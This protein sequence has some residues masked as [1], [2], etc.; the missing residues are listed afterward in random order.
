MSGFMVYDT[1]TTGL[2]KHP[3]APL[4]KQ[5]RIIEFAASMLSI[6]SGK[7]IE[8]IDVLINPDEPVTDEITK[9]TGIAHAD[10]ADKPKF[11]HR[12]AAIRKFIE[13][14]D[15]VLAHNEPFDHQ[16]LDNEL[17]RLGVKDFK[18]PPAFC[19]ISLYRDQ[20]G[21]DPKL[22]VL[23]QKII[24]KP[25]DQRHRAAADVAALVEIVQKEKLWKVL[26]G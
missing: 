11:I 8:S 9:I 5:P 26:L 20:F 21:F 6:T 17:R 12:W 4:S 24:G 7:V 14:A 1:E 23:Y 18:W 13:R 2:V 15:A 16:M 19:T 3:S 22:T 10:V 25:L